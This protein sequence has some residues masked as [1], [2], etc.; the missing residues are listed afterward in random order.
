M[1]VSIVKTVIQKKSMK[2][3]GYS[4]QILNAYLIKFQE[5]QSILNDLIRETRIQKRIAKSRRRLSKA[6]D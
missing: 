6:C 3:P 2:V 5:S 4:S 1:G